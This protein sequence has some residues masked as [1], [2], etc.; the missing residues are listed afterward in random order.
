[1]VKRTDAPEDSTSRA[2]VERIA[3]CPMFERLKTFFASRLFLAVTG[4]CG[5]LM[6]TW[7]LLSIPSQGCPMNMPIYIYC[8]WGGLIVM[9][10]LWAF[11][12][13]P[14]DAPQG[15]DAALSPPP[16]TSPPPPGQVP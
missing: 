9:A 4:L 14:E 15:E 5:A 1:M 7:P 10:A 8:V 13:P 16:E 12:Q 6:L 11:C 2:F 3:I